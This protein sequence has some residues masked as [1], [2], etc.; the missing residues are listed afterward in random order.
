MG[1]VRDRG[2]LADRLLNR[3]SS[4]LL[5][6]AVLVGWSLPFVGLGH[7]TLALALIAGLAVFLLFVARG[8]L[9][10]LA[11]VTFLAVLG[12]SPTILGVGAIDLKPVDVFYVALLITVG[13]E[14]VRRSQ[15]GQ[16][17]KHPDVGQRSIWL[18]IFVLG[19]GILAIYRRD[20]G[21]AGESLV[22][23]LRLAQTMTLISLVPATVKKRE[24][25]VLILR[26][27]ALAGVVTVILSVNGLTARDVISGV[28]RA[29][30]F[31]SSNTIG[32]VSAVLLLLVLHAPVPTRTFTRVALVIAALVGL[33][34]SKSIGSLLATALVLTVGGFSST[35]PALRVREK[36]LL[37][38]I[39]RFLALA[40][41]AIDLALVLRPEALPGRLEFTSSSTM[42]RVLVG[43]AG[44]EIFARHPVIGVGWQQSS[45]PQFIGNPEINR[46]L[47]RRFPGANPSLFPD[48]RATSVH[49][50]YIQTLAEA[51]ITG[52][53][54]LMWA[55]VVTFGRIR[56]LLGE[57]KDD[58]WS[59]RYGRF[60]ALSLLVI[61]VWSNENPLFGGHT[62]TMLIALFLGLAGALAHLTRRPVRVLVAAARP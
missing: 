36:T 43:A 9:W 28:E 25:L 22:S 33:I 34:A 61:V 18:F 12:W 52:F 27:V 10:C 41:V 32:L 23:W 4:L 53:A 46:A 11:A 54:V 13:I 55:L 38:L 37:P 16:P 3:P 50:L 58:E 31:V 6:L 26:M 49:N 8:P 42:H 30:T 1:S 47:R 62:P 14:Q 29:G 40:L 59:Y 45:S 51:G 44:L 35:R 7:L 5:A 60:L 2:H 21:S 17:M 24:D 56:S 19:C 15:A 57:L 20:P 48:V 39:L